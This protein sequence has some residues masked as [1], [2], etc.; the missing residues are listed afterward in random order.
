M[1][2]NHLFPW[3]MRGNLIKFVSTDDELVQIKRLQEANLLK[4]L[5]SGATPREGCL[6]AE[7]SL[8]FLRV[9]HAASPSTIALNPDGKVVG[10]ALVATRDVCLASNQVGSAQNLLRTLVSAADAV[11]YGGA[12][13]GKIPYFV[14]SQVCVAKE[15]RGTGLVPLLYGLLQDRPALQAAYSAACVVVEAP[16]ANP[17][18]RK[19]HQNWGFR[20]ILSVCHEGEEYE[21][22]L[23]DTNKKGWS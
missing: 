12:T 23:W 8:E 15:Y 7:Y 18:S 22:L 9:L 2:K 3:A 6:V 5:D 11:C 1:N 21:A 4:N 13:L 19:A 16:R 17:R 20:E 10:Y 14:I